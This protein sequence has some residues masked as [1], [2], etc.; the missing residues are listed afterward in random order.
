MAISFTEAELTNPGMS[1]EE[2][3]SRMMARALGHND[4]GGMHW[5]NYALAARLI[6][7]ECRVAFK[8]IPRSQ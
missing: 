2:R 6:L 1:A 4:D 7:R 8:P 3:L 5:E